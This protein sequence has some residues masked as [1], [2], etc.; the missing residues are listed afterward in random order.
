MDDSNTKDEEER[1]TKKSLGYK[2]AARKFI[3]LTD[4][5]GKTALH[6]AVLKGNLQLIKSLIKYGAIPIIRD[7]KSRVR[8]FW[9]YTCRNP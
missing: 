4:N 2:N 9:W 5:L 3:N 6:F 8:F 7:H 1:N